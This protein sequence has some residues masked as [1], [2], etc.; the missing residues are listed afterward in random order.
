VPAMFGGP[1]PRVFFLR[2]TQKKR[3]ALEKG[4][5]ADH[6]GPPQAQLRTC[7][8][9]PTGTARRRAVAL[10]QRRH[11]C[12]ETLALLDSVPLAGPAALPVALGRSQKTGR[13]STSL[14]LRNSQ[15]RPGS[16]KRR[17]AGCIATSASACPAATTV[18]PSRPNA[19]SR[20]Q[21]PSRSIRAR[22]L[23]AAVRAIPER[24]SAGPHGS[25]RLCGSFS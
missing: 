7:S 11:L 5:A 10:A 4:P 15:E 25:N 9:T 20:R 16:S 19:P 12:D 6:G 2:R 14:T 22:H 8:T 21:H 17:L 18:S 3:S 23:H 13:R 1:G 24:D